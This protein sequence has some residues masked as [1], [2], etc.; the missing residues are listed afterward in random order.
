MAHT[1]VV[2]TPASAAGGSS[3][4]SQAR[5]QTANQGESIGNTSTV[6]ETGALNSS[7]FW[8][9]LQNAGLSSSATDLIN[10][11]WRETTREQ[12]DSVLRGWG[13]FCSQRKFDPFT[14]V[15][16]VNF[17]TSLY[18][19]GLG[20]ES[21]TKARSALGNFITLPGCSRLADHP[22]ISK[23][24]RGVFNKRPPTPRYTYIWDTRLLIQY[25]QTLK[26]EEIDFQLL[27]S[28]TITLLTILSGQRISTTHA[29][30]VDNL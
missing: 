19:R 30:Q 1:A 15:D 28:K 2:C 12:Y 25:L 21:V 10:N 7:C 11:A 24:V 9:R 4:I 20:Y 17:L 16:V 18:D 14:P 13:L 27:S 3:P 23:L 6:H 22:W 8:S 5:S 26:N 29:F